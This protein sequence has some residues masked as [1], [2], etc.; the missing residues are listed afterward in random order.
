MYY[1]LLVALA[2]K[3]TKTLELF[4]ER[5]LV[6]EFKRGLDWMDPQISTLKV[7]NLICRDLIH[8]EEADLANLNVDQIS[9][10]VV[11][12]FHTLGSFIDRDMNRRLGLQK[13]IH[14]SSSHRNLDHYV[15]DPELET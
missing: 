6:N 3:D 5:N 8:K 11:D 12:Y 10:R 7:R 2:L 14:T 9:I 4:C 15:I 1:E 13:A